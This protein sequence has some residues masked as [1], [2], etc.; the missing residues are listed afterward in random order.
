VVPVSTGLD[1]FWVES[2]GIGAVV[3]CTGA[4]NV[5]EWLPKPAK[6]V[7][8]A[9]A[10]S[11]E[12]SFEPKLP[13]TLLDCGIDV[14]AVFPSPPNPPRV[15]LEESSGG[16]CAPPKL[17]PLA[18]VEIDAALAVVDSKENPPPPAVSFW[19]AGAAPKP[20]KP[21]VL[22]PNIWAGLPI[23]PDN[24]GGCCCA[25]AAAPNEKP[26]L[27]D[28]AAAAAGALSPPAAPLL[29][30]VAPKLNDML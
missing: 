1:S 8:V 22:L 2:P 15:C 16:A 5:A 10:A 29:F 21:P 24:D 17:N 4:V 18:L 25:A 6:A 20:P 14:A 9:L 11:L 27:D 3:A 28:A 13:L 7:E 23:G 19:L 12:S 26:L 30:P